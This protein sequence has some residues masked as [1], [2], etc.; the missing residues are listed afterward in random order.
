M[1]ETKLDAAS[2]SLLSLAVLKE[3]ELLD[4]IPGSRL[5]ELGLSAYAEKAFPLSG[6][7]NSFYAASILAAIIREHDQIEVP[8]YVSRDSIAAI[9]SLGEYSPLEQNLAGERLSYLLSKGIVPE[10]NGQIPIADLDLI[11]EDFLYASCGQ[12]KVYEQK[13]VLLREPEPP[14]EPKVQLPANDNSRRP[15]VIERRPRQPARSE[16]PKKRRGRSPLVLVSAPEETQPQSYRPRRVEDVV[17]HIRDNTTI[18][19]RREPAAEDKEISQQDHEASRDSVRAYLRDIGRRPLLTR[20]EEVEWGKQAEVV[21]SD[22][23]DLILSARFGAFPSGSGDISD[24]TGLYLV[25]HQI[26]TANYSRSRDYALT[27]EQKEL[28]YQQRYSELPEGSLYRRL[29]EVLTG[30]RDVEELS[31]DVIRIPRDLIL[32]S[33]RD[34]MSIVKYQINDDPHQS[35]G[36]EVKR[37]LVR[38]L[39]RKLREYGRLKDKMVESN[40]RLAASIARKYFGRGLDFLDLVQEG[41]IG[42]MKAADKWDYRL[43]FK[44]STYAICWIRQSIARAIADKGKNIRVPVHMTELIHKARRAEMTLADKLGR[45]A[46]PEEVARYM[47]I[48]V[49]QYHKMKKARRSTISL[50]SKI[51]EGE[52]AEL[53]DFIAD[54]SSPSGFDTAQRNELEK[55]LNSLLGTLSPRE[56]KILRMRFGMGLPADHTLEQIG[57]DFEV[58]RERIRQIEA[59]ALR[60]LRHPSR[61]KELKPFMD[62]LEQ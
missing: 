24:N 22:M 39:G 9:E 4:P 33:A 1:P 23:A 17:D 30:Q 26:A 35:A 58:S 47:G 37:E 55:I 59:K 34:L 16:E 52:D 3:Y 25:L 27:N 13:V 41:N 2:P 54:G 45:D 62:D 18:V 51:G 11:L 43:G 14:V 46:L 7:E 44:F 10:R 21:H 15:P 5:E 53:G 57:Q 61:T 32:D 12:P 28:I 49:D 29:V 36:S 20:E 42:L 60:R 19:R 38:D 48:S 50:N 40:L 56:E 8:T 31:T 6:D